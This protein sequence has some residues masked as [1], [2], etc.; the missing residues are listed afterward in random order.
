M[1]S[2]RLRWYSEAGGGSNLTERSHAESYQTRG[3]RGQAARAVSRR[4]YAVDRLGH[5]LAHHLNPARASP[6]QHPGDPP[7]DAEV[8]A[9]FDVDRPGAALTW[10]DAVLPAPL[11]TACG[12]DHN[13][14]ARVLVSSTRLVWAEWSAS[15]AGPSHASHRRLCAIQS[16]TAATGSSKSARG[17]RAITCQVN[18]TWW[19]TAV[20]RSVARSSSASASCVAPAPTSPHQKP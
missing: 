1:L 18:A 11:W 3:Q 15:R 7:V 20:S 19:A 14:R 13:R 16:C 4:P 9:V 17:N 12:A 8:F 5:R 2:T 6:T 10:E